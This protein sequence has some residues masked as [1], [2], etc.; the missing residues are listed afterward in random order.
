MTTYKIK[1]EPIEVEALNGRD[2]W[3]KWNNGDYQDLIEIDSIEDL[4]DIDK[5]D[6]VIK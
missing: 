2:V 3:T 1:L 6:E 5:L 4:T